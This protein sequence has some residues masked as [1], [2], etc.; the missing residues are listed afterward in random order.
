MDKG[1][2]CAHIA[3]GTPLAHLDKHG[4][5]VFVLQRAIVGG[6]LVIDKYGYFAR[7]HWLL[8]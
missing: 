2:G 5:A 7:S 4:Q 6:R 8:L 1:I 3:Q